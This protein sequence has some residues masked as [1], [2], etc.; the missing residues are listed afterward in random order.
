LVLAKSSLANS[1]STNSQPDSKVA[2]V[3]QILSPLKRLKSFISRYPG[4]TPRANRNFTAAR[5]EMIMSQSFF[6]A[7]SII[8]NERF[9]AGE[10]LRANR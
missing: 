10:K 5:L 7:W 6:N 9:V 8:F 3:R 4:L 2:L 1:F